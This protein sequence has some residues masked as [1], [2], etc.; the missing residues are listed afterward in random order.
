MERFRARH[1]LL[2]PS[3][4]SL[5]R[6][7]LAILFPLVFS[8]RAAA[9]GV[10]AAAGISDVL[11]GWLA[12]RLHQTTATGAVV[13]PVTDKLFVLSVVATL[14]AQRQLSVVGVLLLTV[15]ELGELPLVAWFIVSHRVRRARATKASANVPGKAVTSLQFASIAATLV[16]S[17]VQGALL[18][19]TAGA[20]LVAALAY[21]IREVGAFRAHTQS[22]RARA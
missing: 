19:A 17:R 15:R 11:D 22:E 5:L 21:W 3:L 9:L 13:D 16:H 4:L 12:R 18:D 10:L 8:V 6:L 14:V 7:P 20:G 2:P 1:L